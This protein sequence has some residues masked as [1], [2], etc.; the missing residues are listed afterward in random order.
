MKLSEENTNL[1]YKLMWGVQFYLNQQLQVRPYVHSA[2]EY[3]ALPMSDKAPVRDALWKNPKLIDAYLD[4]NPD[5]LPA[6]EQEIIYKWKQFIAD[7]FHIFRFLKNYT[8]FI[9]KR[10]QVY[11]VVGL[12]NSLAE[13]FIGRPLPILVE[14]V[15]L[16]FKGQ[17]IYD[18]LLRPHDIF[19][20]S[21]VRSDLNETYM[22]AKQNGRI[23]TTLEPG[24]T[25]PGVERAEKSSQEWIKKVEE[26]A[27]S[28][29]Q[30]HGGPAIQSA[31]LTLLRASAKVAEA[32]LKRVDEEDLWWLVAQ[33]KRAL[34]RLQT[35]LERAN[36]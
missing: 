10:S 24:A 35:V 26:I 36:Q 23:I 3:A 22:I 13:L 20:G 34:R 28:S 16:P 15:L 2:Q 6:E 12:N 25:V 33:A 32:A 11:G 19:F 8:I 4:L 14:A 30:M 18:G 31:A 29:Q 21:G 27:E 9:G 1:F 17:I 5:H 7:T